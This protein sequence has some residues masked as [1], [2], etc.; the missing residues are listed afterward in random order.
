MPL[1]TDWIKTIGQS[2]EKDKT[3]WYLSAFKSREGVSLYDS[4]GNYVFK[5]F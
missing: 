2:S 4:Q 5:G 1:N 3:L